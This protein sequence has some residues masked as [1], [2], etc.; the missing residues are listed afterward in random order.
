MK[1]HQHYMQIAINE[2]KKAWG[3]T[4]P[5]PLV[6]AVIVKKNR[7]IG[8]GYHHQ[9]GYHHAEIEALQACTEKTDGATC[10]VTL[11]PCSSHG[12]TPPCT[13]AL[14]EAQINHIV[15]GT[16][17][18]NP[19][20]QGKGLDILKKHMKITHGILSKE[21]Q[22]INKP[23]SYWIQ[24]Q[25]PLV[26]LKMAMTLDG[27]IATKS[28]QSQWITGKKARDYVQE[29]RKR[30]DAIMVGGST[31]ILDNPSL[32]VREK[33]WQQPYKFVWSK[34]QIPLDLKLAQDDS[35]KIIKPQTS[36]QWHKFLE[37]IGK[38]NCTNL[39]IEGGGELAANAI[40]ANIVNEVYL[41]IAPKILGGRE[42]RPV[43]G[44]F[45]PS[46]LEEAYDLN[47]I[48]ISSFGEDILIH[49]TIK[50]KT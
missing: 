28:G 12:H 24:T 3:K 32:T 35:T 43:V 6:G 15:I 31:V 17:D 29:L 13:Q 11:E 49:G 44:G 33:N 7:I 46:N 27:K 36:D 20:H 2:A 26:T 34:K 48:S 50:T 21:C 40:R 9:A 38:N 30:C 5:N 42:S 41:F 4:S 47:Q 22:S 19:A 37:K 39:L 14:I 10:Y 45:S 16:L 18:N 25:K 1:N 8:L 23:F